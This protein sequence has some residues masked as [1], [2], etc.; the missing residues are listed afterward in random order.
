MALLHFIRTYKITHE[1]L[2]DPKLSP[3]IEDFTWKSEMFPC[4]L[5]NGYLKLSTQGLVHLRAES[6]ECENLDIWELENS[7]RG[8]LKDFGNRNILGLVIIV[9]SIGNWDT[10]RLETNVTDFRN[11]ETWKL[12]AIVKHF[13]RQ[14][15]THWDREEVKVQH[16]IKNWCLPCKNLRNKAKR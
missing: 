10:L 4:Y 12:E 3:M 7:K 5:W 15:R 2:L 9:K 1:C 11:W 8:H 13:L 16:Q 14:L 6:W